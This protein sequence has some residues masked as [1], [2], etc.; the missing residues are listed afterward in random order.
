[1]VN[2]NTISSV[3]ILNSYNKIVNERQKETKSK[4]KRT[5]R[6]PTNL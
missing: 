3:V 2:M 5:K 1:M 6:H 4:E